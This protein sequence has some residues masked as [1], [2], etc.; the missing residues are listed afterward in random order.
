MEASKQIL[1]TKCQTDLDQRLCSHTSFLH[2]A[3]HKLLSSCRIPIIYCLSYYQTN[4]CFSV[5]ANSQATDTSGRSN[6]QWQVQTKELQGLAG[7]LAYL[8][9]FLRGTLTTKGTLRQVR[10]ALLWKSSL[11]W[12]FYWVE[13][14]VGERCWCPYLAA[15]E[16]PDTMTVLVTDVW[17]NQSPLPLPLL[18]YILALAWRMR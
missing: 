9:C 13:R 15:V 3:C 10:W 1:N 8:E 6:R 18:C 5:P 17:S 2:C 12:Q 4:Y 14:A 7:F 16:E 11:W